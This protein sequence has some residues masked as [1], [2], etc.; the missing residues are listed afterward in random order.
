MRKPDIEEI[1][2]TLPWSVS[3]L[4]AQNAT[5]W[6]LIKYIQKCYSHAQIQTYLLLYVQDTHHF[7]NHVLLLSF[8]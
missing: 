2:S 3:V 8:F 6:N 5:H 4:I 7:I 1:N